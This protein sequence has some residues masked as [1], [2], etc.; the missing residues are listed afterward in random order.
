MFPVPVLSVSEFE[1]RNEWLALES[2]LAAIR[3]RAH[4]RFLLHPNAF[5]L[6]EQD[7]L[8]AERD[9]YFCPPSELLETGHEFRLRV[10]VPGFAISQL[11][12]DVEP[13]RVSMTGEPLEHV[14]DQEESAVFSELPT[15][16]HLFRSFTLHHPI[17]T[18][19]ATAE[20]DA[21]ILTIHLPKASVAL[22][23]EPAAP[24]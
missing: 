9:L 1:N 24:S 10:A 3:R 4:E 16:R 20:F 15:Y 18:E 8:F 11:K 12:V 7:W 21:G 2:R 5:G 13:Y 22:L 19:T 6:D 14:L 17:A 23:A